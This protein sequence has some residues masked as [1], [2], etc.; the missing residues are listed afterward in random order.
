MTTTTTE[1]ED[2]TTTSIAQK[3]KSN[4]TTT[5]SPA[6]FD[7]GIE[8]EDLVADIQVRKSGSSYLMRVTSN[9][10]NSEMEI[11]AKKKGQ[12]NISWSFKT[13][14]SGAKKILTSRNL[15]GFTLFLRFD[16]ETVDTAKG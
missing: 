7:D 5:T 6:E 8:E 13:D 1:P 16:G 15:K 11:I 12:K 14:N 10:E 9:Q 3:Q 4:T 2:E